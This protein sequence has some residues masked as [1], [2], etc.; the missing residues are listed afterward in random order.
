MYQQIFF[1]TLPFGCLL[2]QPEQTF[3]TFSL[4]EMDE[5]DNALTP[6]SRPFINP[7]C[8]DQ[9]LLITRSVGNLDICFQY[10]FAIFQVPQCLGNNSFKFYGRIGQQK[11]ES[12]FRHRLYRLDYLITKIL[13]L[14]KL[15]NRKRHLKIYTKQRL[16]AGTSC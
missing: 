11:S 9:F 16:I 5:D 2:T 1:L 3:Q 13:R 14:A 7:S 4:L 10:E 6:R 8:A 12:G 15:P